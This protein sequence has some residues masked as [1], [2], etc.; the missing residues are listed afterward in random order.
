MEEKIATFTCPF[1]RKEHALEQ[2]RCPETGEA[3]ASVYRMH[4]RVLIDKY[5]ILRPIGEGGMG[6]VYEAKQKSIEKKVAVKFLFPTIRASDD[7]MARFHNEAKVAASISHKNIRDIL[8]MDKTPDGNPFIVME[9]LEGRSLGKIIKNRGKLSS[10]TAARIALQILSAL[11]GVHSMGIVHR[12]LKPD[13]VFITQQAGGEELVKIVDFG[14]SHLLR[15][16]EGRELIQ[17]KDDAIVGTP[18]YLSPEQAASEK[19]DERT[20][21]Y[22]VGTILYEMVTGRHPFEEKN[23]N[24]IIVSILTR[25]P[26]PPSVLNRD[27][28]LDFEAIILKAMRK[29]PYNRF[30]TAAEFAGEIKRFLAESSSA[31]TI[32]PITAGEFAGRGEEAG[33]PETGAG[34]S[35]SRSAAGGPARDVPLATSAAPS[36]LRKGRAGLL[37]SALVALV[38]CIV[39]AAFFIQ[40]S[41]ERGEEHT[42][43]PPTV[44]HVQASPDAVQQPEALSVTLRGLTPQALV[45]VDGV[46]HPEHPLV[47]EPDPKVR[48]IR[49]EAPGYESWEKSVALS[50]DITLD[51]AMTPLKK[52]EKQKKQ[53]PPLKKDPE[54]G[55]EK[56]IKIDID[57]PVIE[58]KE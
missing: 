5:E 14:I 35:G 25:E 31:E 20:D 28:P 49:I 53:E 50:N 22:A 24:K 39:V 19:V 17:T 51:V 33:A 12:D 8:D 27:L 56:K 18:K 7:V 58:K 41:R 36:V 9:Y 48:T 52:K 1:C 23:Y 55:Q 11:R 47:L 45:Y 10:S 4:G 57:Y 21:L 30:Q 54:I 6:I 29:E 2:E 32:L 42:A 37:P 43:K 40:K 26:E 38:V 13:N 3:V 15:P 34:L 44:Q 16:L 46:L